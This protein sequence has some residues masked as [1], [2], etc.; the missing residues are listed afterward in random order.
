MI[1]YLCE[2]KKKES[3]KADEREALFRKSLKDYAA[4]IGLIVDGV[5]GVERGAHGK[6]Y[7]TK[8]AFEDVRF[9]IS[10][11]G[12]FWSVLFAEEEV[13][14]DIED[15]STHRGLTSER[16]ER[17]AARFFAEDE[18]SYVVHGVGEPLLRFFRVWT[19]KEA[20]IKYTGAG[21]SEGLNAFSVMEPPRDVVLT[22][23]RPVP[24][25]IYSYCRHSAAS[26]REIFSSCFVRGDDARDDI[27][28][29]PDWIE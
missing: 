18:S 16:R 7:F 26:V 29:L 17:I 25:M 3:F 1:L 21:I 2:N 23:V 14:L 8:G 4:R 28:T 22:T 6:P 5:A 19:A 13:G 20:Y 11:S 15:L 10:H 9:S 12:R 27:A 24:D